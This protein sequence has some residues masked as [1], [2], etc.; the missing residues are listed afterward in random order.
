MNKY[1]QGESLKQKNW[2]MSIPLYQKYRVIV[3]QALKSLFKNFPTFVK[4]IFAKS[5]KNSVYIAFRHEGG[6]GDILRQK[7]IILEVIKMF[8]NAVIDLYHDKAYL[9]LKDIKN[10][11]FVF[12]DKHSLHITKKF[13]SISFSHYEDKFNLFVKPGG[14]YYNRIKSNLN[15]YKSDYPD[16]FLDIDDKYSFAKK[17]IDITVDFKSF[18]QLPKYV[19]Y[20]RLFKLRAGVDNL[21]DDKLQLLF[22]EQDLSKFGISKETKYLTVQV[23]QGVSGALGCRSWSVENWENFLTI[24]RK[25]LDKDI[26]IIQVGLTK[27]NLKNV[28]INMNRLT[29]L[30]ELWTVLKN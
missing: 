27:Y 20:I 21:E 24:L 30:D 4:F 3:N 29:T 14:E 11:R 16:C 2:Y 25:K 12:K 8:P 15:K 9:L 18:R 22:N 10:I 7:A 26:K 5:N 13:Y 6:F 17:S 23:G 19:N 28:E 1:F